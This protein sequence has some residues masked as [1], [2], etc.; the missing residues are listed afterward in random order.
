MSMKDLIK[1]FKAKQEKIALEQAEK[2]KIENDIKKQVDLKL[3]TKRNQMF[4][5]EYEAL[6][7]KEIKG[8]MQKRFRPSNKD[9][10][11]N[12]G[13]ILN[14]GKPMKRKKKR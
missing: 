4:A 10:D 6:K 8:E 5:K 14:F 12:A 7:M 11:F 3:Q 1:N 13:D 2:R 9:F